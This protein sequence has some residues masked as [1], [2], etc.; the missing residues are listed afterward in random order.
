MKIT[1]YI[2]VSIA[3]FTGAS[4]QQKDREPWMDLEDTDPRPQEVLKKINTHRDIVY[5][6][7]GG[8]EMLLDLYQPKNR[9]GKL[10]PAIV[11]LH[12]G[13]W[14]TGAKVH[15]GHFARALAA[16]GF[17]TV[18][19]DYRLSGESPF[20]AQIEDAKAAVRWLRANAEKWGVNPDAIGATGSSAGGHLAALLATSGDVEELE[21]N[22]GNQEFSSRIQAAVP[23]CAQTD[24]M[25]ERIKLKSEDPK[26][27]MYRQFLGG[28]QSEQ[29]ETYR[30][31]S[32]LH[33][34][35]DDDAPAF[36]LTGELDDP[37]T[38]A[39]VIRNEYKK[40]NIPTGLHVIPGAPHGFHRKQRFF[41]ITIDQMGTFFSSQLKQNRK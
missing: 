27:T 20:P 29:S 7:N 25:V 10:L 26:V 28:T 4:A 35:S 9:P 30:S 16:R 12:G 15:A 33:Y 23:M 22:G 1:F 39:E 17:V 2:F 31:A 5:A 13:G 14:S 19:I 8:R 36:F 6:D 18:S 11:C 24:L 3:L 32:P 38:R 37:S 21:G 40:Q 41:D 34:F